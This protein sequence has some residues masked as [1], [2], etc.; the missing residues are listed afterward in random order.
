MKG[1]NK[2]SL[3]LISDLVSN[4]FRS[5]I[6]VVRIGEENVLRFEVGMCQPIIVKDYNRYTR[7]LKNP[8]IYHNDY[9]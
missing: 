9:K 8:T 2:Q 1:I 5:N 4:T 7:Q 3:L 6:L